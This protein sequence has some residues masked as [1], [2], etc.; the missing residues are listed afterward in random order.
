MKR[1]WE[2]IRKILIALEEKPYEKLLTLKSFSNEN[3]ADISY[4][5][6]LLISAD[7]VNGKMSDEMVGD[8]PQDF[9]VENLTFKGHDFLL[10]IKDEKTWIKTAK[11]IAKKGGEITF[12]LVKSIAVS[13]FS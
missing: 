6:E 10:S 1:D 11:V 5:M 13:F 8:K 2:I 9:F 4:N 3:P 12:E 7:F